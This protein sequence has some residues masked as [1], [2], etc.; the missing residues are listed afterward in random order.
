MNT[1]D[2]TK[3]IQAI[4]GDLKLSKQASEL[5]NRYQ[6]KIIAAIMAKKAVYFERIIN[7]T[8]AFCHELGLSL[9]QTKRD[10]LV[11]SEALDMKISLPDVEESFFGALLV[12]DL[13]V[14]VHDKLKQF[15]V[16]LRDR[17]IKGAGIT[18]LADDEYNRIREPKGLA[19]IET[20]MMEKLSYWEKIEIKYLF[21]DVSKVRKDSHEKFRHEKGNFKEVL[22]EVIATCL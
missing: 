9:E 10:L 11:H 6:E 1:E 7:D 12:F 15:K 22:V 14:K 21:Y 3:K 16:A 5:Q 18:Y 13:D 2:L 17:N 20:E 8:K 19:E 4:K